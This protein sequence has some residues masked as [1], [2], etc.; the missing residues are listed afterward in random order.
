MK[1]H[2]LL[3]L[4]ALFVVLITS[5]N[6]AWAYDMGGTTIYVDN[7]STQ[8]GSI[9]I[10]MWNGGWNTDWK[11]T[12]IDGTDYWKYESGS[13]Y[14]YAG[15]LWATEDYSSQTSNITADGAQSSWHT[16]CYTLPNGGWTTP[17]LKNVSYVSTTAA[18]NVLDGDG[19]SGTPYIVKPGTSV[20]VELSGDLIDTDCTKSFKFGA[21]AASTT[22][23]KTVVAS[24][25][26]GTAYS[27]EGFTGSTRSTYS[28]RYASA[29]TIYFKTAYNISASVSGGHGTVSITSGG[30]Y[31]YAGNTSFTV[32]ASPDTGY[33]VN[34][35]SVSGGT[36]TGT[37]NTITVTASNS[38][39]CSI[40]VT[41]KAC[42]Y[43]TTNNVKESDGTTNAG[44]YKATYDATSISYTTKPSKTG[45][46]IYGLY[47]EKG[48]TNQIISGET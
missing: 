39:D 40:T 27:M 18:A 21:A 42:Q 9:M 24:A 3:K 31:V 10:H 37:G 7:Y 41:Y 15:Y 2:L 20:S 17:G 25:V 19:K 26:K 46:H 38:A 47:K 44:T 34:S 8:W 30:S 1:K 6:T 13:V 5:I 23:T 29:G 43:S 33:E 12:Q 22:A 48:L 45:Y 11:F 4:L 14:G 32:T 35:W 36:K 28:S 16:K